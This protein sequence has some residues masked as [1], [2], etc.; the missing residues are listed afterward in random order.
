MIPCPGALHFSEGNVHVCL[1]GI[2]GPGWC[3]AEIFYLT[4]DILFGFFLSLFNTGGCTGMFSKRAFGYTDSGVMI[5]GAK[6][7]TLR[8]K[9]GK[10]ALTPC[11]FV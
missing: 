11:P 2:Y 6:A 8:G 10:R 4:K 1:L 5:I 3:V 7:L 9:E